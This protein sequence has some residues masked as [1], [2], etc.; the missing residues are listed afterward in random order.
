MQFPLFCLIK[1]DGVRVI[2]A[3]PIEHYSHTIVNGSNSNVQRE[4]KGTKK[5]I[6]VVES[7]DDDGD[8]EEEIEEET[9]ITKKKITTKKKK[10]ERKTYVRLKRE[11]LHN[12]SFSLFQGRSLSLSF[13][14]IQFH[15]L[16]VLLLWVWRVSQPCLDVWSLAFFH[17]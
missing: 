6:I 14:K 7:N 1:G 13:G 12:F 8:E 15:R 2:Q 9:I 4:G 16:I 10:G 11:T 3:T 17:S 5:K